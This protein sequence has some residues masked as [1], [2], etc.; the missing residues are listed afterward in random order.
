MIH[1]HSISFRRYPQALAAFMSGRGQRPR[2]HAADRADHTAPRERS[3]LR[4]LALGVAPYA[5]AVLAIIAM[6]A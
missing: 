6:G 2:T 5:A 4:E 1:L 3:W